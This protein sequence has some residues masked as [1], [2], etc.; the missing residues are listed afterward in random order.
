MKFLPV[1]LSLAAT[2]VASSALAQSG[3]TIK[4]GV[5]TIDPRATSSDLK[6]T[7]PVYKPGAAGDWHRGCVQRGCNWRCTI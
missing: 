4:L 1:T 5:G 3:Y 2:L 6:G 7:L